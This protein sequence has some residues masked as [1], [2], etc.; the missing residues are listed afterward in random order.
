[1]QDAGA[2]RTLRRRVAPLFLAALL[3]LW[4]AGSAGAAD[5]VYWGDP[6]SDS[7]AFI[8]LDGSGA[9]TLAPSEAAFRGPSGTAIDPVTER[10]YWLNGGDN[11]NAGAGFA[12][13]NLNGVGGGILTIP[14][15][16][17]DEAIGMAIDP[18]ARRIYWANGGGFRSEAIWSATLEG[19]DLRRF[20]TSP[21]EL[22]GPTGLA[23]DPVAR[24][25][26]WVNRATTDPVSFADLD[27]P[28]NGRNLNSAGAPVVSPVGLAIDPLNRRVYWGN[29]GGDSIS[30]ANLDG[31]GGAQLDTTGAQVRSPRG[32]AVDAF[33]GRVYWANDGSRSAPVSFANLDGSGHGGDLKAFTLSAGFPVLR[34]SPRSIA[35]PAIGGG[36]KPGSVLT[37]STGTWAPDLVE[38]F[39]YDAAERFSFQWSRNGA[40]VPGATGASLSA[41]VEGDYRCRVTASNEAGATA[42]SS[43]PHRVALDASAIRLRLAKATVGAG[44]TLLVSL[45]NDSA[46]DLSG[47]LSGRSTVKSGSRKRPVKLAAKPFAIGAHAAKVVKL[48]LPKR[49]R[50]LL[51][52]K[53]KLA[54]SLHAT[55]AAVGGAPSVVEQKVIA[56][57]KRSRARID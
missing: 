17:F 49:L 37:C 55:F 15:A 53:R 31:S 19:A 8:G 24:R 23:I 27:H 52:R 39:Y 51:L 12:F 21:A 35:P 41:D 29:L 30:V 54:I 57:L 46:L 33:G 32:V 1:M 4:A 26:Y 28:G 6:A 45:S 48:R 25:L 10:I 47:S 20:D 56:K 43:P 44:D 18:V 3:L 36:A 16:V 42:A 38:A 22:T 9:D 13:A 50:L 34:V 11:N 40:D 14:G 5:R 7:L 2:W